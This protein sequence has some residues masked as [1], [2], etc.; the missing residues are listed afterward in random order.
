MSPARESAKSGGQTYFVSAQIGLILFTSEERHAGK[1][2]VGS[3][4]ARP[5]EQQ[6]GGRAFEGDGL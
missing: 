3:D 1:S 4:H 5:K 2:K 6:T